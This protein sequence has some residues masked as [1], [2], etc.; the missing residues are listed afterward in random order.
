VEGVD[1]PNVLD[2]RDGISGITETLDVVTET[3]I[4]LLLDG[5]SSRWTLVC[6]LEV[7]DEHGTHLVPGVDGSFG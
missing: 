1:D 6:A 2:V 3:L 7:L 4:M 5:L